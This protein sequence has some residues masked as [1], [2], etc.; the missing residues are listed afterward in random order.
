MG[1]VM[2]GFGLH[3]VGPL[4]CRGNAGRLGRT[5]PRAPGRP[6]A[7]TAA[8]GTPI[9]RHLSFRTCTFPGAPRTATGTAVVTSLVRSELPAPFGAGLDDFASRTA[10][11]TGE[12]IRISRA[13]WA[14]GPGVFDFGWPDE[15][16]L[17]ITVE[18]PD[19]SVRRVERRDLGAGVVVLLAIL[20]WLLQSI[21]GVAQQAGVFGGGAGRG[22]RAIFPLDSTFWPSGITALANA[23]LEGPPSVALGRVLLFCVAATP[24]VIHVIPRWRLAVGEW[25]L[26]VGVAAGFPFAL[27]WMGERASLEL[28][29]T[30]DT[31]W[32]F[33][34]LTVTTVLTLVAGA[35]AGAPVVS[36]QGGRG[37]G[38]DGPR[39]RG[40]G[41]VERGGRGGWCARAPMCRPP[42]RCCGCSGDSDR[43]RHGPLGARVVSALVLCLLAGGDG[44]RCPSPGRCAPRPGWGSPKSSCS[45]WVPSRTP[46]WTRCWTGFAN[47]ADSLDL[48]GAGDVRADVRG[49]G[50][51]RPGRTRLTDLRHPLVA[52]R[53]PAAGTRAGCDGG[54]PGARGRVAVA[55]RAPGGPPCSTPWRNRIFSGSSR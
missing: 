10:R 17:S 19:P 21:G 1:S 25:A 13:E 24:F 50:E 16:L 30:T 40:G 44:P 37:P 41:R 42:S 12:T 43:S 38:P 7:G 32:I 6:C 52:G 34:Q 35:A 39:A 26:P 22:Q 45:G 4:R 29:G 5:P 49:L 14:Q 53:S 15:A 18:E 11:A 23:Q 51:Q 27:A 48:V 9:R 47:L 55:G 46:R 31:R 2:A 8:R 3:G 28:L 20:A 36:A 54:P 33:F